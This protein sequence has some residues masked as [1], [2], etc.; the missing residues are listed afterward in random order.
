MAT[1]A[2]AMKYASRS[3]NGSA[4]YDLKRVRGYAPFEIPLER[5]QSIPAARPAVRPQTRAEQR[6]KAAYGISALAVV[7]FLIIAVMIVFVLLAYVQYTEVSNETV[8][9]QNQLSE[10]SEAENKLLV[11]Y[12]SAYN[13][14]EV[15]E[16][17]TTVL[18]MVKPTDDQ[19]ENVTTASN[20]K[21]VVLVS[22]TKSDGLFAGLTAFFSS[23]MEYFKS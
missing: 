17:A 5:P 15:K 21:A 3:T 11:A 16:Y 7:G 6:A 23:L 20:D 12:E 4:A 14:N 2:A 1:Q 9:L 10:L 18:G 19:I 22:D 13:I 8:Q